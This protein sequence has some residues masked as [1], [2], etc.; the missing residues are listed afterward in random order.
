M[1]TFVLFIGG[2]GAKMNHIQWWT[3]S[4]GDQRKDVTFDGYPW[5]PAAANGKAKSATTAFDNAK[6]MPEAIKKIT[7]SK[8][9][10]IY[11]VG[12]SSGC[13]IA[14]RIDEE[15]AKALGTGSKITVNL[16]CLDGF[17]PSGA[18]LGRSTTQVWSAVNNKDNTKTALNYQ[19]L[20][21][22]KGLNIYQAQDCTNIWSLHFSL[23]NTTT[24]DKTV[25]SGDDIPNGY[26]NCRANLC[27]LPAA[28]PA[29]SSGAPSSPAKTGG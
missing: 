5:P 8:C 27:W 19:W 25:T 24:S 3:T 9:N 10:D 15:L 4:A 13:A 11:I 22:T 1:S 21:N 17:T 14:N 18:Q 7:D 23:V 2:Y 16:V 20:K 6:S 26:Q 29:S 28:T 12:H